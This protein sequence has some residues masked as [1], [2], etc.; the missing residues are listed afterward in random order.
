MSKKNSTNITLIDH[1]KVLIFNDAGNI[2]KYPQKIRLL[3]PMI[4]M[5]QTPHNSHERTNNFKFTTI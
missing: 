2:K 4:C 1:S 3:I 5:P